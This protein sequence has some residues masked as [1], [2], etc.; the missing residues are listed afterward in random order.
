MAAKLSPRRSMTGLYLPKRLSLVTVTHWP[1]RFTN[2]KNDVRFYFETTILSRQNTW[3]LAY[4]ARQL[5]FMAC[6]RGNWF[7]RDWAVDN[8]VCFQQISLFG[9]D[10]AYRVVW[11]RKN[12]LSLLKQT[13]LLSE[14]DTKFHHP[15]LVPERYLQ[16]PYDTEFRTIHEII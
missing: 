13:S 6:K 10:H 12:D 5:Q 3:K 4:N 11:R 9:C 8:A 16:S 7:V 1:V 15:R 14:K 2:F